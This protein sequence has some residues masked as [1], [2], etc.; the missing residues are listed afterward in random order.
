M[1]QKKF[2]ATGILVFDFEL[3]IGDRCFKAHTCGSFFLPPLLS[4]G[5]D[6]VAIAAG[7][8][9]SVALKSDGSTVVWQLC[10]TNGQDTEV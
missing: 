10:A 7:Q 2:V 3:F 6:F 9:H 1:P 4:D 5:N 8:Y